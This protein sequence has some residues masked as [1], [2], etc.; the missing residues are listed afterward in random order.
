[1]L[2]KNKSRQQVCHSSKKI[3]VSF[4]DEVPICENVLT[5]AHFGEGLSVE[6]LSRAFCKKKAN[7]KRPLLLRR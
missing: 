5:S 2:P 3:G 4:A 6:S 1:M 7:V